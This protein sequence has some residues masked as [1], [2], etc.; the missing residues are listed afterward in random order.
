ME[1]HEINLC[2]A[3][4][5]AVTE[6]IENMVFMAIDTAL[7]DG[8]DELGCDAIMATLQVLEP[9]PGVLRLFMP[10][11]TAV[12]ISKNLYSIADSELSEAMICDVTCELLNTISGRVMKRIL[13]GECEF[14]FGLPEIVDMPL[15]MKEPFVACSF[16]AD[17]NLLT[18]AAQ[19]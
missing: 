13:P 2:L 3:I 11:S 12:E 1:Q 15:D 16:F 7:S 6:S 18:V 19:L 8:T 17:G 9:R 4:K 10:K 14:H 5:A